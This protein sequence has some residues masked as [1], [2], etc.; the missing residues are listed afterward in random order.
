MSLLAEGVSEGPTTWQL[1][2]GVE[3]FDFYLGQISASFTVSWVPPSMLL[4][5]PAEAADCV[6]LEWV[7]RK[8]LLG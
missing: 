6:V 8:G 5:A 1:K 7:S 2:W 4:R 3:E